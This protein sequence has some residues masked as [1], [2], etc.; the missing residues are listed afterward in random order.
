MPGPLKYWKGRRVNFF[1]KGNLLRGWITDNANGIIK[2]KGVDGRKYATKCMNGY[3]RC[4]GL[5]TECF[6]IRVFDTILQDDEDGTTWEQ[7]AEYWKE[8]CRASGWWFSYE[9][10]HSLADIKYFFGSEIS[11]IWEPIVIFNG[12]GLDKDD[13]ENGEC[14]GWQLSN[15]DILNGDN[16]LL[17]SDD[18]KHKIIFFSSCLI[19]KNKQMAEKLKALF[20]AEALFAYREEV[21]A[22]FCYLVE[23]YLFMLIS[24]EYK[25]TSPGRTPL[26]T[27]YK[28]T[29]EATDPLKNINKRHAKNHPLVIY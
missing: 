11:I 26:T 9:R 17:I 10:V 22:N 19:G 21:Y 23:S 1:A 18:N 3:T 13:H 24:K 2:V 15:G 14:K 6:G 4:E 12:H 25:R 7:S 28:K 20:R 29:V 8:F 5:D 16:D 27:L